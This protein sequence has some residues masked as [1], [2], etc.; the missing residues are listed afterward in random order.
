MFPA[1]LSSTDFFSQNFLFFRKILSRIPSV[2]NS[3]EPDQARHVATMY[4][5][6][7]K[8]TRPTRIVYILEQFTYISPL[9]V[10]VR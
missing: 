3:W 9:T 7:F 6:A 1:F 4:K 8:T 10:L 5:K 2:S